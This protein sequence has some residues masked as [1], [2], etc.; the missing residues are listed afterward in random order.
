MMEI[1]GQ[2]VS[3][4]NRRIAAA[5]MAGLPEVPYEKVDPS[6]LFPGSKRTWAQQFERRRFDPRNL[7]EG[8]PLP[9]TGRNELPHIND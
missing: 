9:R 8:E 1:D 6:A 5:R 2:L 3:Y 7:I 4:D